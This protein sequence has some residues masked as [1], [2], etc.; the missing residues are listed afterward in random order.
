MVSAPY[1]KPSGDHRFQSGNSSRERVPN[2]K[3]VGL[4]QLHPILLVD[5]MS[6]FIVDFVMKE[7]ISVLDATNLAIYSEKL[8]YR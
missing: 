5:S 2:L 6:G 3:L 8:P 7:R 4:S 1:L